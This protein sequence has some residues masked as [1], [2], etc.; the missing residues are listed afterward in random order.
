MNGQHRATY[1]DLSKINIVKQI[2]ELKDYREYKRILVLQFGDVYM[3]YL[4]EDFFG[5]KV[6][7]LDPKEKDEDKKIKHRQLWFMEPQQVVDY[8]FENFNP[9]F[10]NPQLEYN[11]F[12]SQS[13]YKPYLTALKFKLEKSNGNKTKA[14][15]Q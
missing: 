12:N 14:Q 1:T 2:K 13:V 10:R 4:G 11:T 6:P 15:N 3:G 8:Y 9:I 7:E 5:F